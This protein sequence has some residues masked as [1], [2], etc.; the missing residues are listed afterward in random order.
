[1]FF[2]P[3]ILIGLCPSFALKESF[4]FKNEVGARGI[5]G[6]DMVKREQD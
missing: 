3:A 5:R 4:G 1:M 2:D 6:S